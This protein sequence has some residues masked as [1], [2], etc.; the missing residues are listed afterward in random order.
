MLLAALGVLLV[1]GCS[2]ASVQGSRDILDFDARLRQLLEQ[3]PSTAASADLEK[4]AAQSSAQGDRAVD[5]LSAVSFY[6]IAAMAAW[7][8]GPAHNAGLVPA[9]IK[10][11]AQCAN[12]PGGAGASRDCAIFRLAPT[13]AALDEQSLKAG[14]IRD[15]QPVDAASQVSQGTDLAVGIYENIEQVLDIRK[16]FTALD[17]TFDRFLD[18]S[19]NKRSCMV[20]GMTRVLADRGASGQQIDRI[21]QAAQN[22]EA[23]MRAS[24]VPIACH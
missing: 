21:A 24:R 1:A 17:P 5:A 19:V 11:D 16:S 4:L 2:T 14:E 3:A 8:A 7:G 13:L 22:A 9:S 20:Q 6:R 12:L 23:R 15:T 18:T 10:G